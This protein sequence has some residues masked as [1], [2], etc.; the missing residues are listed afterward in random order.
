MPKA[1]SDHSAGFTLG[2]LIILAVLVV[3]VSVLVYSRVWSNASYTSRPVTTVIKTKPAT[4]ATNSQSAQAETVSVLTPSEQARV[5]SPINI[6]GS[7]PGTW[8]FEG[9]FPV[10]LEDLN[11]NIL[12]QTYAQAQGEWMTEGPVEFTSSLEY[13]VSE[14]TSAVLVFQPDDPSGRGVTEEYRHPVLLLP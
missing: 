13:S 1:S 2:V 10:R 7:A 6:T 3:G 5:T 12:T 4:Q 11:G 8:F 14:Q 9:S